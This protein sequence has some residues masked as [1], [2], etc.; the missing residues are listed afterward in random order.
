[1]AATACAVTLLLVFSERAGTLASTLLPTSAR[2][3]RDAAR[4]ADR[5]DPPLRP[6]RSGAGERPDLLG[7]AC[8]SSESSRRTTWGTRLESPR[9]SRAYFA[10][11]PLI[12]LVMLLPVTFNGIGTSQAAFVWFFAR[13]G[14]A[15]ASAF[16]M[17]VLFVGLGVIGNLPG[18]VLYL[19][20]A[21][22]R[23][24]VPPTP[25]VQ[26]AR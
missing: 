12:L 3:A 21:R 13:A 15:V 1:M 17:S 19:T 24:E 7:G 5:V 26:S 2:P 10:F 8:R 14:V 23:D 4:V 6:S 20:G 11:V 9:R 16:S 22:G 18:G 25:D